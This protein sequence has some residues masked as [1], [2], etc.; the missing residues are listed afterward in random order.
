M[1]LHNNKIEVFILKRDHLL[2]YTL[3]VYNIKLFMQ[4]ETSSFFKRKLVHLAH[5]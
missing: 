5:W 4:L 2:K 3:P 1:V